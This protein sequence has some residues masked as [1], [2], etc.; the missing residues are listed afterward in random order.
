MMKEMLVLVR[1]HSPRRKKPFQRPGHLQMFNPTESVV[2][3]A[4]KVKAD[5]EKA[6]KFPGGPP[7]YLKARMERRATRL[8]ELERD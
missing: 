2:D 3:L 8:A 4:E 6:K 1:S 5:Q 7:G